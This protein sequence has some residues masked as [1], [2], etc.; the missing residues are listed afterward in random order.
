MRLAL[1]VAIAVGFAAAL[2]WTTLEAHGVSASGGTATRHYQAQAVRDT[3]ATNIV[4]A[5]LFDYRGLDTLIESTVVFVAAGIAGLL[6]RGHSPPVFAGRPG[7]VRREIGLLAPFVLVMGLYVIATGHISPGGGFQGGVILAT[8]VILFCI[9]Y[10]SV[11]QSPLVRP[12]VTT[13][14]ESGAA[15]LFLLVALAG[16]LMGGR[17]LELGRLPLPR[18]TPGTLLSA[19]AIIL[20]NLIVGLKVYAAMVS[21]FYNMFQEEAEE[22]ERG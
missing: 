17:F 5:I 2:V 20:L 1:S 19:G 22:G 9:L 21:I 11:F 14:L 10:G 15:L 18:G 7:L 4:A 16:I 12:T 3:G 8:P 6:L 13:V